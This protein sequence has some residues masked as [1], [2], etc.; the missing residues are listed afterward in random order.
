[1]V[2]LL[3]ETRQTS[4]CQRILVVDIPEAMQIE[5]VQSRDGRPWEEIQF[6]LQSQWQRPQRLAAADDIIDNSADLDNLLQQVDAL[7][8]RYLSLADSKI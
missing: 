8:T 5:R 2:P 1:M 3:L 6:I 4:M 7:H